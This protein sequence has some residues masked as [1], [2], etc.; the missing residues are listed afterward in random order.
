MR[1]TA[2]NMQRQRSQV[3]LG[4]GIATHKKGGTAVCCGMLYTLP[5][6]PFVAMRLLLFTICLDQ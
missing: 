1:A 2:E 6:T 5:P 4:S 3:G